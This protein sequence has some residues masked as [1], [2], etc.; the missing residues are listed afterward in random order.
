MSWI[1]TIPR[2]DK[3]EGKRCSTVLDLLLELMCNSTTFFNLRS[4]H[5]ER[6]NYTSP[7]KYPPCSC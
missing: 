3:D 5:L 6:P 1:Q 2:K 4:T 7:K